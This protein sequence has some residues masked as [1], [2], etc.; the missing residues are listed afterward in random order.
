M[1]FNKT[2]KIIVSVSLVVWIIVGIFFFKTDKVVA[3][4]DSNTLSTY[5]QI[6][7][8]NEVL[9]KL[10]DN[11]VDTLKIE[12]LIDT[13]I[14]GMLSEL[15]PH[16]VYF[17][18]EDFKDFTTNTKGEFGGLGITISK[19]GK[20]ITVVSP[21]EGTPAYRMGILAGDKIVKV[22]GESV[23]GISTKDAVKKMRG[24]KGSKVL[25]TIKRPGVKNELDF[26]IT[27]DIIEI[28]SIP[29]AFKMDNG[30]GYIRVRQFNAHTTKEL[31]EKLNEL[32]NAGIRGLVIDLRYN[33]GGLLR[34]A[35]NTVNEFIGA[36]K[37]V[38]YTKGKNPE[39]NREYYTH[40][41]RMRSGYPIVVLINQGSASAAEIFAGTLQDYD[42]A[43]V[44]G[45]TSFGKGSVQ[46]LFP[47]S[48]N[49]GVK[50]TTAKYYINSGRC[51]HKDIND[52]ILTNENLTEAEIEEMREE[53]EEK[54]KKDI[55]H[56]KN[57]RIVYGGGGI[58]PDIEIEQSTLNDFEIKLRQKNTFFNFAVK[59]MLK[60]KDEVS[61]DFT[62]DDTIFNQFL[63]FIENDSINYEPAQLDS[64]EKWIKNSIKKEI[65]SKKFGQEAG[66]K[67]GI[68]I[69][70]QLNEALKYLEEF[71]STDKMLSYAE[72]QKTVKPK[73]PK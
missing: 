69:D 49:H 22:D 47:L 1:K 31:R 68:K 21:L 29:Y 16:T 71:D 72:E 52:E 67:V 70:K 26:R 41:N 73:E 40:Y 35:I 23:V 53:A 48:D 34:E 2:N 66:Y 39:V 50:V 57:G 5:K 42:K 12:K 30:A 65:I 10:R 24:P 18:P 25:V 55:H 17:Q 59:Y 45:K 8:F 9:F 27:R 54:S 4:N 20:Y 63:T 56:T 13:A 28:K 61:E 32:E 51:I 44:V 43:L 6:Q 3:D 15:D 58:T 64:S 36:D 60:H 38:V 7:Q 14:E 33:P 37:R 46:R 62:I 19:R 11:Y